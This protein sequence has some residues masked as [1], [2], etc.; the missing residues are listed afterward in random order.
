VAR[1]VGSSS[2]LIEFPADRFYKT[3]RRRS[4]RS[5]GKS[6]VENPLSIGEGMMRFKWAEKTVSTSR[7]GVHPTAVIGDDVTLDDGVT[8]GAYCVIEGRV[9]IGAGTTALHHSTIKGT[10][11]VGSNCKLGPYA[12]VGT[13]PQHHRYDGRETYLV[14][15]NDVTVREFA[16]LHRAINT[17]IE[18]ATR[19]GN[20]CLLMVGS[21]VAHTVPRQRR[22][23]FG[24]QWTLQCHRS[25]NRPCKKSNSDR[26]VPSCRGWGSAAWG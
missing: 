26:R 9:K 4:V 11:F 13:D 22:G 1:P 21:H 24:L 20:G 7:R 12:A 2:R 5:S 23:L 8:I 17:G 14:V 25:S 6:K 10:T 3:I 19:V 18:N 15:G 16:T